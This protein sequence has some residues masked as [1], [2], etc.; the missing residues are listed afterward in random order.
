MPRIVSEQE[1]AGKNNQGVTVLLQQLLRKY[2][3]ID[4]NLGINYESANLVLDGMNWEIKK[5]KC[6]FIELQS[7]HG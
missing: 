2:E 4:L 1:G 5:E 3:R 7:H 6:K